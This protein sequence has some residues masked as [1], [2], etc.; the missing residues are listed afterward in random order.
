MKVQ[1]VS[2]PKG[3]IL[4]PRKTFF[5][6]GGDEQR[7]LGPSQLVRSSNPDKYTNV[8]YGSKNRSEDLA[9]ICIENKTVIC[10]ARRPMC[11]V[12]L[13][14]LCLAKLPDYI[15]FKEDV[16]YCRPKATCPDLSSS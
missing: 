13:L 11:L 8:E 10:V 16:L 14:D 2:T 9:E 3:C 1:R 15:A 6:R 4:L 7:R 5:I 12:Y